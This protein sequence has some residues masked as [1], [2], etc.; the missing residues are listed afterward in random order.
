V[1]VRA[2]AGEAL[3]LIY[4]M[5]GLEILPDDDDELLEGGSATSTASVDG[6]ACA[7]S[8]E[9]RDALETGFHGVVARMEDLARNRQAARAFASAQSCCNFVLAI[10]GAS[11]DGICVL[12][13]PLCGCKLGI[14]VE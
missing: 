4:S 11:P 6:S 2:A 10:V 7:V 8:S 12:G 3:G 9:A 13:G 5:C 14:G 1:A